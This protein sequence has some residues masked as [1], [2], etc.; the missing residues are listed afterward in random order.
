MLTIKSCFLFPLLAVILLAS[1]SHASEQKRA[2]PFNSALNKRNVG[3]QLK[4]WYL[5][6]F[7]HNYFCTDTGRLVPVD[8]ETGHMLLRGL[9]KR[10][11][12]IDTWLGHTH[13]TE[14]GLCRNRKS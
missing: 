1:S 4:D 13:A 5:S 11:N 2:V 12:F 3:G 8:P 10:E 7:T 14:K 6:K 9:R